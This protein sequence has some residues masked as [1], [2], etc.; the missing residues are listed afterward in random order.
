MLRDHAGSGGLE[1]KKELDTGS[2]DEQ[3]MGV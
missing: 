2:E 1:E 3:R